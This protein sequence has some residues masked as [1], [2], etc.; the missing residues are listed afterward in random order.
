MH[1]M[2]KRLYNQLAGTKKRYVLDPNNQK[3][4][5]MDACPEANI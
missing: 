1:V 3:N 4:I 2:R 5:K